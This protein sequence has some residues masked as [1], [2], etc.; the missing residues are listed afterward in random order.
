M[1]EARS[2]DA[3]LQLIRFTFT[4]DIVEKS[5]R[6]VRGKWGIIRSRNE[7]FNQYNQLV[8]SFTIDILAE[9]IIGFAGAALRKKNWGKSPDAGTYD[10]KIFKESKTSYRK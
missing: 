5:E 1:L 7:A 6:I 10:S 8:M 2:G 3:Q 9:E 4:Y